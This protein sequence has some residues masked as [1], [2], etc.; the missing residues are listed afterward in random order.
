[1]FTW[2]KKNLITR[3]KKLVK[4]CQVRVIKR[5]FREERSAGELPAVAPSFVDVLEDFGLVSVFGF[6]VSKAA[7]TSSLLQ[8][9]TFTAVDI[10]RGAE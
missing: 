7:S 10:W 3:G 4:C 6:L 2:K 5:F 8:L 1:M 9:R